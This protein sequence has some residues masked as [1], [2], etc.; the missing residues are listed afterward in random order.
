VT[1]YAADNFL[2]QNQDH[3][4]SIDASHVTPGADGRWSAR[5]ATVRGD[6]V[7]WLSSRNARRNFVLMLRVYNPQRDFRASAET[8]PALT[9]LSCLGEP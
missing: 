6:A 2:A 4:A 5:V 1:L 8:L 3:A 7:Y 9:R